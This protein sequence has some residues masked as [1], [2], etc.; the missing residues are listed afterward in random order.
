M[1]SWRPP[2]SIRFKAIGLHWR[3]GRLLA[4]E[5]YDDDGQ[6][7]GVRPLGGTVEFGERAD[8]AL[9]RE[10]SE[11]LGVPARVAGPARFIENIYTHEGQTGHEILAVF[12]VAIPEED[13]PP[14]GRFSFREANGQL[15]FADWFDLD[16]LDAPSRPALDPVGLRDAL[17]T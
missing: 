4:A 2:T 17:V 3:A 14:L 13:L 15:C 1:T 5:V 16:A 7:K 10:F 11:E 9:V 12:D 8:A 6:L